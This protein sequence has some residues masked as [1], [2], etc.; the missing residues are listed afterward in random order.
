MDMGAEEHVSESKQVETIII[1]GPFCSHMLG[2]D[3]NVQHSL[4]SPK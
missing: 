2:K 1:I 4:S 3:V